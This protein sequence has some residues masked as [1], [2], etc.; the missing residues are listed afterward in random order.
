MK[1]KNISSAEKMYLTSN[2]PVF[3]KYEDRLK[4]VS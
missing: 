4:N 1:I 3:K 2:P